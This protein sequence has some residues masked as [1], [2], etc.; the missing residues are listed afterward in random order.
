MRFFRL[1]LVASAVVLGA[2]GGGDDAA[3]TGDTAAPATPVATTPAPTGAAAEMPATGTTHQVQMV[4][5]GTA[6]K[7]VPENITIK[8]GDAIEWTLVS[9]QPHNVA[10]DPAKITD[11]AAKSQLMA[12][13]K[14]QMSEL[15][16][17]MLM[18]PDEKYTISFAGVPAGTYD[19]FCTPHLA[20]NM[21][22]KI[23]VT[24]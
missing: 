13:M 10:F 5:E 17:P 24:P 21:V 3:T 20:M 8:Q 14:N 23:T 12:N 22:G 19:Y 11:A 18:N 4:M 15:S 6:Y 16:G 7:F 1:A 2:C 9:G